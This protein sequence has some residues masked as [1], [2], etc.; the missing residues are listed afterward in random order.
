[1]AE[2]LAPF[3]VAEIKDAKQHPNADRL[4]VC[5]VWNGKET[6]N[7][8]CGAPNAR[9]GIKVILASVGKVQCRL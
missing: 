5:D 3:T 4:R 1:M 8:V 9:A 7:I 6:L 2:I